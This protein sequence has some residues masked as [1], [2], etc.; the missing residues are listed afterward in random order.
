[1]YKVKVTIETLANMFTKGNE[2]FENKKDK[3][4]RK[5]EFRLTELKSLIRTIFRE[6]SKFENLNDMKDQEGKI[7][8][9]LEKKAPISFKLLNSKDITYDKELK[10]VYHKGWKSH[11]I[12][13]GNKITFEMFS[14]NESIL[15]M[16]CKLLILSSVFGSIGSRSRK[17]LGSFKIVAF[18]G[19][20]DNKTKELLK[21]TPLDVIKKLE[22]TLNLRKF[23]IENELITFENYTD[24]LLDFPYVK[25][26]RIKEVSKDNIEK[27]LFDI[28]KLTHTKVEITENKEEPFKK[29]I[30][31]NWLI[32]NNILGQHKSG[33]PKL[34][35]FAS[36]LWI[37]FW[38]NENSRYLI[39]KI[40]NYDYLLLKLYLLRKQFYLEKREEFT[41]IP[42]SNKK[43]KNKMI[44]DMIK[45]E[46]INFEQDKTLDVNKFKKANEG[47]INK[48]F[49]EICKIGGEK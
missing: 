21:E 13:K 6:F 33:K 20:I 36:P 46:T 49:K 11:G 32:N 30:E 1:M 14:S 9:N 38:E 42:D 10:T 29:G 45:K 2:D 5:S 44:E 25:E 7:F 48:Y 18:E 8:G 39:L 47:Y 19:D 28:S 34:D 35:R 26:I 37:S 40:L 24:K 27:I 22:G 4:D 12:E 23:K 17:G 31:N 16:Y 43:Q 41:K 15:D 3:I